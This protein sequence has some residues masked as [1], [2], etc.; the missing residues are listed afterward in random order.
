[1]WFEKL[2][3]FK[4]ESPEE[5]RDKIK[6]YNGVMTSLVNAQSY[7]C[8][9]L[10]VRS[11]K[12]LRKKVS[13]LNQFNYKISVSE[14]I[15]DVQELHKDKDNTGAL[16]QVA[17]QFN[18][19]EMINPNRTPEMGVGI[20]ENDLTQ[21]PACAVACGAGTIYRNYF[22]KVNRKTGQTSNNQIDCLSGIGKALGNNDSSLWEMQN[23]YALANEHG[24]EN[25][26]K[27]IQS[28]SDSKYDKLLGELKVGI[29]WNTQVTLDNCKH[30]VS[31]IYCSALPVSYSDYSADQWSEFAQ[32]ILNATYEATLYAGV[33]NYLE[34][35]N[36]KVY[37]TLVGGGAFGNRESW[38]IS[39]IER[40][41]NKF[42]KMP[43]DIK[44]VSY[45]GSN[46]TVQELAVL[47][48]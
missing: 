16:F 37:L 22:V 36:N 24:L 33:L 15:G 47:Y 25:I 17:S 26:S 40:A 2:T 27:Q 31:Q 10:E 13:S 35:G 48:K 30:A 43:L 41:L 20:Y 11:L 32:L 19:L 14:V 42:S 45:D 9:T 21:G 46:L 28:L 5:V 1:M 29:Q 18:L 3:G 34:T 8:G 6:V 4:E 44:V 38:I 7:Q 12:E 39:A 23:G